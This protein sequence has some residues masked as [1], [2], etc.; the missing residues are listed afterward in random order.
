MPF[1]RPSL[2]PTAQFSGYRRQHDSFTVAQY[3]A[4]PPADRR[5][6]LSAV[7]KTI[8]QNLPEE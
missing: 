5:A 7:R 3:L 1:A 2:L 6:A 8:N 4:A